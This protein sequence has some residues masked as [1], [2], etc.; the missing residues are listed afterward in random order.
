MPNYFRDFLCL[1]SL[2]AVL[3]GS[4]SID[5]LQANEKQDDAAK[6]EKHQINAQQLEELV[7]KR[8]G[9]KERLEPS[10][11]KVKQTEIRIRAIRAAIDREQEVQRDRRRREMDARRQKN[12]E[13]E[14][15]RTGKQAREPK[16][17]ERRQDRNQDLQ[18]RARMH[19]VQEAI[20][21]LHAADMHDLAEMIGARIRHRTQEWEHGDRREP[22]HE[23][24]ERKHDI[25]HQHGANAEVGRMLRQLG[26]A[27][28]N[29]ERRLRASDEIQRAVED[30]QRNAHHMQREFELRFREIEQTVQHHVRDA[31]RFVEEHSDEYR[32][33]IEGIKQL[34]EH[35]IGE[36]EQRLDNL[37]KH[38]ERAECDDHED[39][40]HKH[41]HPGDHDGDHDHEDAHGHAQ[42]GGHDHDCAECN[43]DDDDDEDDGQDEDDDEEDDDEEDG[44]E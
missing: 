9:L 34:I 11:P 26:Q 13:R 7:A 22:N 33:A 17:A 30:T 23:Q 21:H 10:H 31:E 20:E 8:E 41:R 1:T 24:G 40:E 6:R 5:S 28:Q 12:R 16:H 2:L 32:E 35:R 15:P 39:E 42:E 29:I 18:N 4:V 43:Q 44:D 36:I 38:F 19:H 14:N 27:V 25:Q 3:A 37:H